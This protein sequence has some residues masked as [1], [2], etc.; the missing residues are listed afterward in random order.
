MCAR[1]DRPLDSR[2]G[3]VLTRDSP[4]RGGIFQ[5][6]DGWLVVLLTIEQR[7]EHRQPDWNR[8]IAV[9]ITSLVETDLPMVG[10]GSRLA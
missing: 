3:L 2:A 8:A 1:R 6:S 7:V 9:I 5:W 10:T 4:R